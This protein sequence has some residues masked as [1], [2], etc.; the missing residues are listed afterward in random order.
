MIRAENGTGRAQN[1]P[2][3][4]VWRGR[5]RSAPGKWHSVSAGNGHRADLVSVQ[6]VTAANRIPQ[7]PR[8]RP[9]LTEVAWLRQSS[10]KGCVGDVLTLARRVWMGLRRPSSDPA[11]HRHVVSGTYGASAAQFP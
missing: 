11:G 6:R 3:G 2:H 4:V 9:F 8:K 7:E 1:C 10:S 5:F